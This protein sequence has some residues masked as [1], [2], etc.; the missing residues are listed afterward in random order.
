[1][2]G[3]VCAK[4]SVIQIIFPFFLVK[5]QFSNNLNFKTKGKTILDKM[6]IIMLII[7]FQ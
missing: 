1:M 7:S 4:N 5:F 2:L 3:P 6:Y